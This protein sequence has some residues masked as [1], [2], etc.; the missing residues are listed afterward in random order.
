VQWSLGVQREFG[1]GL[2]AE[3][4]YVGNRGVWWQANT[5]IAPNALT[6][7][8]LAA[9]GLS[10]SNP[11]DLKL[12]ATPLNQLPAGS[13]FA[14]A[15]YAGF[16]LGSTVAQALRPYPEYTTL[17]NS[18][19]PDGNT[20]YDSL[21]TKVTKRLSHGLDLNASFT[22]SKQTDIAAEQDFGYFTFVTAAVNDVTN[23][24]NNKYLSAYDQP[25]LFVFSSHYTTP[26]LHV[27][28]L[29]S[30]VA[31]DWELGAVL[32]Y[33]SGFPIQV[34]TATSGLATYT[35]QNTFVDRVPGVPLFTQDLNCHCFDPNKTFVL[36]PKAWANPA[37]GQFGTAAAYYNDYRYQR[38]PQ[39][40]LS[41]ARNFRIREHMTFQLRAE[42]TNI[43]NRTYPNNPTFGNAFA[44][45]T[46]NAANGQTTGG[47]GSILANT[48]TGTV[49]LPPRQGQIVA[50]FQF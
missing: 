17:T 1:T 25:L 36:N 45:Q 13:P 10:L 29:V 15:P 39:E 32:R 23:R 35:F 40:N 42:F 44:T 2:L 4:A 47:F 49:N 30:A 28:K 3:A 31:R 22:W 16:P 7:Q 20:W 12:L 24:R 37:P 11:A 27:N 48:T 34:P 8:I 26:R 50:R 5:L 14:V 21:Q 41:I 6:S 43:F 19:N 18:W 46:V 38:R 33:G 9:H